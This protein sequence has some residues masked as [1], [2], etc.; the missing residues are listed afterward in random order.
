MSEKP[1]IFSSEMVRQ[2][3]AGNKTQTRR[4]IKPQPSGGWLVPPLGVIDGNY[5]SN[6][7]RSDLKCPYV[8]QSNRG[9]LWVRETFYVD[10]WSFVSRE[11]LAEAPPEGD[12]QDFTYY[13]VD[14]ECCQQIPE[15]QCADVGKPKWRSPIHMPRW[16]SRI[17]LEITGVRV[18]R[19]QNISEAD[20]K[21]EGIEY[22]SRFAINGVCY[23]ATQSKS[24]INT[25]SELWDKINGKKHPWASNPFVWVIEFKRLEK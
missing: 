8:D 9:R 16:A 13:R 15:C 3:L 11:R 18:E 19:L 4:V 24:Y 25:F 21:A 23:P 5:A 17:T 1:I 14:G 7:C 2:I 12:W 22:P 6:G 10:H 20:A